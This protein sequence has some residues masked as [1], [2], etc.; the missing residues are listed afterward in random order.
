[1]AFLFLSSFFLDFRFFN[2]TFCS[3]VET[4]PHH[5]A[6]RYKPPD[7]LEPHIQSLKLRTHQNPIREQLFGAHQ[8]ILDYEHLT[9]TPG[10]FSYCLS[11]TNLVSSSSNVNRFPL[12]LIVSVLG[13][14]SKTSVEV[15]LVTVAVR[16][17][18]L[19]A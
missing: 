8:L 19:I 18:P 14:S 3:D 9:F 5:I 17:D 4:L 10:L 13:P 1:M 2:A 11:K 12:T 16:V 15:E 7:V 6:Q